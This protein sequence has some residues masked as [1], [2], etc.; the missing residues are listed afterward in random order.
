MNPQ[1]VEYIK[2]FLTKC[3]ISI[4]HFD[5][6]NGMLIPRDIFLNKELY[7]SVK[8][9]ISILKQVFTSSALTSLQSTAEETQKWPL[10]NLVRQ[11]LRSCHYKMTPKRISAGYT[12]DGKKIYKRMFIVEKLNQTE[13]SFTGLADVLTND[14]SNET[15]ETIPSGVLFT[16]LDSS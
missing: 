11:V 16:N 8:E 15:S 13:S 5:D 10:L 1:Q 3:N 7:N 6:L 4:T 2:T 12:K 9:E 14:E